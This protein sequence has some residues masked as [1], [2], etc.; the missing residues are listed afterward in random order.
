MAVV[1]TRLPELWPALAELS[2][3][4]GEDTRLA[5]ELKVGEGIHL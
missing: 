5:G 2:V 3:V 4:A 1:G